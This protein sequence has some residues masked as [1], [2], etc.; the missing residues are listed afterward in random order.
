MLLLIYRCKNYEN[1]VNINHKFKF[2][3]LL[4]TRSSRK[5]TLQFDILIFAA[6]FKVGNR[7][8]QK[9][10]IMNLKKYFDSLPTK[11]VHFLCEVNEKLTSGKYNLLNI[12]V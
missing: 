9:K 11:L 5:S 4:L 12:V 8:V 6:Y 3:L 2:T 7:S 10:Y 1:E